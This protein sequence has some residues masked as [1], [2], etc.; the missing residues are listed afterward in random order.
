MKDAEKKMSYLQ[1]ALEAKLEEANLGLA[2]FK[3]K[4]ERDPA[5]AFEWGG[6]AM[7]YA[8]HIKII[9]QIQASI[10]RL[11]E[12]YP[13]VGDV[14]KVIRNGLRTEAINAARSPKRSTSPIA[15]VMEQEVGMAYAEWYNIVFNY[16][17]TE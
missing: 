10:T 2:E 15:N 14:L 5:S 6:N 8:A 9:K 16:V 13:E 17:D 12:N 7:M 11:S 3:H 1:R 4:L